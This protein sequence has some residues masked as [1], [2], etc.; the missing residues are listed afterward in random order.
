MKKKAD[1][2][3]VDE[4]SKHFIRI[5]LASNRDKILAF[6]NRWKIT[7]N[8]PGNTVGLPVWR[9][10]I[11]LE[12]QNLRRKI[13]ISELEAYFETPDALLPYPILSS[14][15]EG[16]LREENWG[17]SLE[18]TFA[19]EIRALG[20]KLKFPSAWDLIL[21]YFLFFD[22]ENFDLIFN[23]GITLS[24]R[25]RI[26]EEYGP[27]GENVCLTL[28]ENTASPDLD[29][30]WNNQVKPLLVNLKARTKDRLRNSKDSSI[31]E[32]MT[33]RKTE[34]E[35]MKKCFKGRSLQN[36][37]KEKDIDIAIAGMD[38]E[39]IDRL[40]GK[41]SQKKEKKINKTLSK[42]VQNIRYYR[43]KRRPLQ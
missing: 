19:L 27:I 24:V 23:H 21:R 15:I 17:N 39:R 25:Y 41:P 11:S 29:N 13:R 42:K 3:Q 28:S 18:S 12:C 31:F 30:F 14:E 33:K 10:Q 35:E 43:N 1:N 5:K 34:D 36:E 37:Y 2:W 38:E 16:R 22:R 7:N 20:A 8:C 40:Y 9:K 4:A 6:R 32:E 26:N